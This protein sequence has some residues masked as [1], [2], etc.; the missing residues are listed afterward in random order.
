[1]ICRAALMMLIVLAECHL[2]EAGRCYRTYQS[3]SS[4]NGWNHSCYKC[5]NAKQSKSFSW[6]EAI[7]KLEQ[8]KQDYAAFADALGKVAGNSSGSSAYA[9]YQ[10]GGYSTNSLGEFSSYPAGNTLYG[11]N[12]Y[13]N[14]PL[15]DLNAT[16][17]LHNKLAVQLA[18]GAHG[19]ASDVGDVANNVYAL[20]NDRQVKIAQLNAMAEVGRTPPVQPTVNTLRWQ[21]TTL[22]A[23]DGGSLTAA[24]KITPGGGAVDP[25]MPTLEAI[26]ANRCASCHTGA[27]AAGGLNVAS[28]GL[29]ELEEMVKR[30]NLP[31]DHPDFMPQKKVDSGHAPGEPLTWMERHVLESALL[32]AKAQPVQ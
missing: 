32:S 30:V 29:A 1:M 18:N 22:P 3:I 11:V 25:S 24:V 7:I 17:N 10:Q 26:I 19:V 23:A 14:H 16:L 8:T 6:K 5:H 13:S 21:T 4:L 20:E 28:F 2:V 31:P 15:V 9:A 27:E 12:A